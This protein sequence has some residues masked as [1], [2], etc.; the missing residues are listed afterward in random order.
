MF[1]KTWGCLS[2]TEKLILSILLDT[3]EPV[4]MRFSWAR[5][6]E[7]QWRDENLYPNCSP[8]PL[9]FDSSYLS[10]CTLYHE[11]S[12]SR[13]D[14]EQ[15]DVMCLVFTEIKSEFTPSGWRVPA[16]LLV[17]DWSRKK[18]R[19]CLARAWVQCLLFECTLN[20]RLQWC[21]QTFLEGK[22]WGKNFSL[23]ILRGRKSEWNSCSR[24]TASPAIPSIF[25]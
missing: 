1:C 16:N 25:F 3:S 5:Q 22:K 8:S 2:I 9:S 17:L 6:W 10:F 24:S 13:K 7:R 11:L 15:L 21:H 18:R 20:G 23:V 4:L 19:V 14:R 12:F